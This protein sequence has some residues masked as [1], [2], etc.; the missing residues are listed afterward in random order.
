MDYTGAESFVEC[1]EEFQKEGRRIALLR[2]PRHL[3]R[4]LRRFDKNQ[5][6]GKLMANSEADLRRILKI[7]DSNSSRGR[8]ITGFQRFR[9]E[10]MRHYETL[11]EQLA[12]GQSPHTLFITC[13]DSRIIPNLITLT[14]PGEIFTVRN[15]G[16]IIPEFR[17]DSMPSEGAAIEYAVEVLGVRDIIVCG[18][19]HCG[20][21]QAVI[22]GKITDDLPSVQQWLD[23]SH[24]LRDHCSES[25]EAAKMNVL[26][27]LDNL[28]TYPGV[29]KRAKDGT[30][31]LHA[32]FYEVHGSRVLEWNE[33]ERRFIS[34]GSMEAKKRSEL[35]NA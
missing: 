31:R 15:I 23:S 14:E 2:M 22:S 10:Q 17:T 6:V 16:N 19:S 26:R 13:S 4:R 28:Q 33:M 20:A 9:R 12:H 21:M 18:H 8:L 25:G 11:F 29:A 30:L 5:T 35:S 1:V 7:R 34:L 24:W 27:Q 32:W 3:W